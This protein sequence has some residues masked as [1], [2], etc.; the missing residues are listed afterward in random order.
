MPGPLDDPRHA[1]LDSQSLPDRPAHPDPSR[2]AEFGDPNQ[3]PSHGIF[4]HLDAKH[5]LVADEDL[6]ADRARAAQ[7][8]VDALEAEKAGVQT[9]ADAGDDRTTARLKAIDASLKDAKRGVQDVETELTGGAAVAAGILSGEIVPSVENAT[10]AEST[11]E[12]KIS[13]LKAP[14]APKAE[15]KS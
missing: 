15:A 14:N 6:A 1:G 9:R 12:G 10:P 4:G 3:T 7:A 8:H 5:G 2:M 11:A 13:E